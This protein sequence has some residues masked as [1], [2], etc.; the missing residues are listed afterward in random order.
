MTALIEFALWFSIFWGLLFA[1][2]LESQK[3]TFSSTGRVKQSQKKKKKEAEIK[4]KIKSKKEKKSN[5]SK[6]PKLLIQSLF[7]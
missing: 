7:K 2:L 4:K 6:L 1:K 5:H 3:L